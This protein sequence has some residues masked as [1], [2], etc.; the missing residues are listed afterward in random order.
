[1]KVLTIASAAAAVLLT[2]CAGSSRAPAWYTEQEKATE[3]V[4]QYCGTGESESDGTPVGIGAARDEARAY[5]L[6]RLAT[7]VENG[8][9]MAVSA[10]QGKLGKG[11]ARNFNSQVTVITQ[12]KLQNVNCKYHTA[13]DYTVYALCSLPRGIDQEILK[14]IQN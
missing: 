2:S 12:R 13:S 11:V 1:M 10:N 4:G 7:S 6:G 3:C 14:E 8:T 9:R 5:A